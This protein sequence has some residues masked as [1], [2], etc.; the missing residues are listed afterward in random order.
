MVPIVGGGMRR[1]QRTAALESAMVASSS[2]TD[3]RS[4]VVR[5]VS[6]LPI[7]AT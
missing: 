7:V 6:P 5:G 3:C 1:R 2:L 4:V